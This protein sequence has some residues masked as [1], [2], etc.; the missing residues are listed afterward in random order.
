MFDRGSRL[1]T[2]E[3]L[4][5]WRSQKIHGG[6]AAPYHNIAFLDQLAAFDLSAHFVQLDQP[7]LYGLD[8][9]L[10]QYRTTL[11]Q[12]AVVDPAAAVH[13]IIRKLLEG[14]VQINTQL[15]GVYH[16]DLLQAVVA[17][18]AAGVN[19]GR[20]QNAQRIIVTEGFDMNA[21]LL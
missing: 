21:G 12:F 9:L 20:A 13:A 6:E 4:T 3:I 19:A 16:R 5:R 2:A 11:D 14:D 1:F 8:L 15:D 10:G 17:V 7:L 18:A